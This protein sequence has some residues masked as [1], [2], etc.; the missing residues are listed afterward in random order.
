MQFD[1]LKR[2]EF[3]RLLG[4]AAATWPLAARAQ[5]AERIYRIGFLTP[6]S[7][8]SP[9]GRDAFSAA[10]IDGMSK[11]GYNE[12]KNLTVEWRYAAGDYTRLTGFASELVGMNPPVIVT[13]GTAAARVLQ[14]MTATIPVVVAAAVDLVG[15]GIVASLA[16]PGGNITGLSVIDTDISAKQLELLRTFSPKLLHVAVLLNPGNSANP[17]VLKHVEAGASVLGIEVAALNAAT[18]QAIE[19]AFAEAVQRGAGAVIVAADAFF[20]GQGPQIAASAAQHRLP[21]ISLYR[22]HALAGCLMSYGQ[23]VAEFHRRAAT[24]VD[25]I[26]KGAKPQDL[27]VEQPT[28]FDLVINSK[29]AAALGLAIPQEL[30]VFADEVIE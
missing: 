4:G 25:K 28:K 27:P 5:Q 17:L 2:R 11:L 3:I 10:F 9:T 1:R 14:K 30:L 16:R 7:H 19:A 22:D 21:T 29:T 20:S 13:Y 15:A 6:R 8:P 12:G 26:L 24:Y 23:N 18:P